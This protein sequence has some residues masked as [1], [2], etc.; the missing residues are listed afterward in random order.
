VL[1]FLSASSQAAPGLYSLNADWSD[2]SNPHGAW[3]YNLNSVPISEHQTF[4]WGQSGW[5]YLWIG[6][7]AV[8]KGSSPGGMVDPWGALTPPPHDW[9]PT[10][11]VLHALSVPYGGVTSFLNVTWTSPADGFIDLSGR[12]WDAQIFPDRDVS[13]SL[14]IGGDL[15]AARSS[16]LGLYRTDAGAQFAANLIGTHGL[17]GIPVTQGEVVEF[18]VAAQTYYGQFVGLDENV[19]FTP[20]PEPRSALLLLIGV[21]GFGWSVKR[22]ISRTTA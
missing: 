13:W 1:V 22:R 4:W 12:A 16:V 20:V 6:D 5:G 8:M 2:V 18:A 19:M 3:S 21:V 15:F 17:T 14:T 7:G 11:V 9:Q 10:D